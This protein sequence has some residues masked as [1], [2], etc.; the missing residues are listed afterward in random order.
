MMTLFFLFLF[1]FPSLG[2]EFGLVALPYL[3]SEKLRC[4]SKMG[5]CVLEID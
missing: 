4:N 2:C 1:F 3:E 5:A